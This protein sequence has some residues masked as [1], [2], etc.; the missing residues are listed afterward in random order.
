[1]RKRDA[2]S[3]PKLGDRVPYVIIAGAKGMAAYQKAEVKILHFSRTLVAFTR[4][5]ME[6][7]EILL[8]QLTSFQHTLLFKAK[9]KSLGLKIIHAS[10][11]IILRNVQN[12]LTRGFFLKLSGI[13]NI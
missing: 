9:C 10:E 4:V 7:L 5:S 2:G 8:P 6:P 3:A 12:A 13:F 11:I 1:M